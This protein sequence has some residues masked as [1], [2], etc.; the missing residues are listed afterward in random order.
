MGM[1]SFAC[2]LVPCNIQWLMFSCTGYSHKNIFLY[3][4][5]PLYTVLYNYLSKIKYILQTNHWKFF[6]FEVCTVVI[7]MQCSIFQ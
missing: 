2:L 1:V 3:L 7:V 5:R 4:D 6:E